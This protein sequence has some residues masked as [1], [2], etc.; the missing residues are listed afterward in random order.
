VDLC[1]AAFLL[2]PRA[3]FLQ[4]GGFDLRFSPAYYE[5]ADYCVRLWSDGHRVVYEPAAQV[6][7]FEFASST[8]RGKAIAMQLERRARFAEKHRAWLA[9]QRAPGEVQAVHARS[10]RPRG[11]R[12]LVFDDRVP[13]ESLGSGF[14]RALAL[15]RQL[16]Q[17]GYFVTL[18]PLSFP[19][20]AWESVYREVPTT[21][22][23]MTDWGPARVAEFMSAR[24]GY[25]DVII[26]S[27]H[28][29][30]ARLRARLGDVSRWGSRVI[31]DAEAVAAVR[32]IA[33]RRAA[34]ETVEIAA[35]DRLIAEE[36][37]LTRGVDAVLVV[38][39]LE[40]Q[41]F[42]RHGAAGVVVASHAVSVE[43]TPR[44]F[45]D[46]TGLL[47]VG[48]F[49]ML[50]PNCEGVRWFVGD[51]M[52]RLAA[53][54]G[55]PVHLDVVGKDPAA[56]I[57]QL[58][59]EDVS[60]AGEVEDLRPFY[61]RARVFIAPTPVSAGIPL[62]VLHASARGVPVVCTPVLAQQLGWT[63]TEDVL[64]ATSAE[65]F[66]AACADLY[67]DEALW[68][69]LRSSALSRVTVECSEDAFRSALATVLQI[70][71]ARVAVQA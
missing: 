45:A 31:Y 17:L 23:V 50:S 43:P 67:T 30:M 69:R 62:K 64:S 46:R 47:F 11:R 20:E 6:M 34:G 1:S 44:A 10:H 70:S 66:A 35:A 55:R 37:A 53:K 51:V 15:L 19:S 8:D 26:V 49:E 52:P 25:Y 40:R 41:L 21:V 71:P 42:V 39:E 3:L 16:E 27:R 68:Q 63:P 14:P 2:T 22:E 33:G 28:H 5:D 24:R 48:S 38:S 7:H 59:S 4:M 13:H 65:D 56:D 18:Y 58:E 12:V 54:L 29:N 9:S 36:I 32:D 60:I 57:R 61:D